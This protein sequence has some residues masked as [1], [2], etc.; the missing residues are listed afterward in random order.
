MRKNKGFTLIE[1]MVVL[2][3]LA[4]IAILAYNFFGNTM[5]EARLKQ[6]VT[7]YLNDMRILTDA[8]E[9]HFLKFGD[10]TTEEGNEPT[11][12]GSELVADGILKAVPTPAA[13]VT[14]SFA[15][16]YAFYR[17][18]GA[19]GGPTV[20]LDDSWYRNGI[21]SEDFCKAYNVEVCPACAG[22]VW[23][24]EANAGAY[25]QNQKGFC[26]KTNTADTTGFRIYYVQQYK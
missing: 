11:G 14:T 8:Q 25:P 17:D 19:M 10:Y 4:I 24:K 16:G 6:Q 22:D 5:K 7:K 20:A 9:M 3:I 23:D 15:L 1:V 2:S 26:Y 13:A 21:I 12:A 18:E